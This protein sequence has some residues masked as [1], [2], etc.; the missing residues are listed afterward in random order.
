MAATRLSD[1]NL[2]ITILVLSHILNGKF[3][4]KNSSVNALSSSPAATNGN[5]QN[6]IEIGIEGPGTKR[7]VSLRVLKEEDVVNKGFY[8][9]GSPVKAVR[10]KLVT[11]ASYCCVVVANLGAK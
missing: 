3:S 1:W 7:T 9:A 4:W 10:V 6:N 2:N 5:I 11:W 8:V